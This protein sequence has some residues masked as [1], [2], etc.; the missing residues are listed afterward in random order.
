MPKTMDDSRLCRPA[1]APDAGPGRLAPRKSEPQRRKSA[2]ADG[3]KR[4]INSSPTA[5]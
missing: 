3:Q 2:L 1:K 4:W 5:S